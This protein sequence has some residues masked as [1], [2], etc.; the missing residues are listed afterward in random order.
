MI[1]DSS[2]NVIIVVRRIHFQIMINFRIEH[3]IFI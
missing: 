2:I 3:V 1:F